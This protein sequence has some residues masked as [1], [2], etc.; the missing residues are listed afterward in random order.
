MPEYIIAYDLGTGG[1]KASLYDVEGNC[2]AESFVPYE[3]QYPKTGYHEQKPADWWDCV[4]KST[5]QLLE[6]SGGKSGT[7]KRN[8]NG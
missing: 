6:K 1:N 8:P 4:I 2:L 7:Y 3:T 5:Q